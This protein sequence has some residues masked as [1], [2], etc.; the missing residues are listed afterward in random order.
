MPTT[1]GHHH[2]SLLL[3]PPIFALVQRCSAAFNQA[4]GWTGNWVERNNATGRWCYYPAVGQSTDTTCTG[5]YGFQPT[6]E[7]H[8]KTTEAIGYYDVTN[9]RLG[10]A[11]YPV[12]PGA[13]KVTYCLSGRAP[14]GTYQTNCKIAMRDNYIGMTYGDDYRVICLVNVA[15]KVVTDGC[16]EPYGS[17]APNTTS[18]SSSV[19]VPT[20]AHSSLSI[21]KISSSQTS[22]NHSPT[23]T[24]PSDSSP[25]SG[26][27]LNTGD[28]IAIV[29]GFVSFFS[30]LFGIY[31]WKKRRNY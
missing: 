30:L 4:T 17:F 28:R 9:Q 25:S 22:F 1:S 11:E 20:S 2:R 8:L 3:F 31:K 19:F 26:D 10:G 13:G 24:D 6:L 18:S 15:Q 21:T 5:N 14:D 29:C 16:Y 7:A 12:V 23:A 27:K